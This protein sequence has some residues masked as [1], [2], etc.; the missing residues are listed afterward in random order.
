MQRKINEMK[1]HDNSSLWRDS[2]HQNFGQHKRTRRENFFTGN[3]ISSFADPESPL[4]L[5]LQTTPWPPKYKLV[6]LLKYKGYGHSRQIIMSY[7]AAVNST[8]GDDIA[9]AKSF[10]I[11]CEG[12]VLNWYSFLRPHSIYN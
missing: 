9:L 11:A 1:E 4:S 8:R 5:G 3:R 6:S 7:E 10:I 2:P 12:P